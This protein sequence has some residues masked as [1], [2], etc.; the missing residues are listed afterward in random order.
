[1][2]TLMA[3]LAVMLITL[4]SVGAEDLRTPITFPASMR[5]AFLEHM[6]DHVGALDDVMSE[7]A[8]ADFKGAADVAREELALGSGRGFGRYMPVEFREMGL[9]MHRAAD[10]FADTVENAETPPTPAD[11]QEA[12]TALQEIYA[13]CRNCHS[14]FRIE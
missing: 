6:R 9:A 12:V 3:L 8:D 7:L 4:G 14:A 2:R 5:V 13:Q 11:W 1:M 10:A